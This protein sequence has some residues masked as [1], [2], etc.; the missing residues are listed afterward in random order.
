MRCPKSSLTTLS[1]LIALVLAIGPC[2]A[3]GGQSSSVSGAS[4]SEYL[5]VV[6]SPDEVAYAYQI[7]SSTGALAPVSGQPFSIDTGASPHTCNFGCYINPVADPLGRFLFYDF[8]EIPNSGF[9]TMRVAPDTGKL[10]DGSISLVT[11]GETGPIST[12]PK[13]RF[14]FGNLTDY[15]HSSGS[16]QIQSYVVHPDGHLSPAP[17]QP[18]AYGG[19]EAYSAPA[20]S[21]NYV[22]VT[23]YNTN[24]PHPSDLFGMSINLQAG[25][26]KHVS[27]TSDG[28]EPTNQAITPSGKF[29]YSDRDY[30]TSGP[31]DVEIVGFKVNSDGSLTP[32]DQDPQKTPDQAGVGLI[33]SPNSNFLYHV[34]PGDVRAYAINKDTGKLTLTAVYTDINRG[35]GSLVIDPAVKYVYLNQTTYPTSTSVDYNVRGFRVSPNTGE[36]TALPDKEV[37]FASFPTGM[38]IVRPQ[39]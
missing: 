30:S 5:Y 21:D 28:L 36:L 9:G 37:S 10:S 39:P 25:D 33:I 29:L 35:G 14:I 11:S 20:A 19:N 17:G 3:L 12:D 16:N 38:A 22:Y 2:A 1:T 32:I 8:D 4:G 7:D 27:T 6:T 15:G 13:G 18:Y 26:L 34:A 23:D 31:V 24:F